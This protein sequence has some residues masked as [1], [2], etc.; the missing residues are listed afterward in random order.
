MKDRPNEMASAQSLWRLVSGVGQR[1]GIETNVHSLRHVYADHITRHASLIHAQAMM[2]HADIATTR[3]YISKPSLDE[4][5]AAV[6][7]FSVGGPGGSDER[8]PANPL[9]ARR[10]FEPLL[11]ADSDA[12]P[13]IQSILE[14][15]AEK[16]PLYMNSFGELERA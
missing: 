6:E 7:G 2:G 12:E 3:G 14:L 10:G 13:L 5:A 9:V 16:V 15:A 1:V 4:L 8:H 11:A